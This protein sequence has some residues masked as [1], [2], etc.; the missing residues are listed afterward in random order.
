MKLSAQQISKIEE[1]LV[2]NGIQYDDIKLELTDHI[3]SE[4]EEEISIQGLSF[5]V[6]LHAV[7]ENWKEQLR[8]CTSLWIGKQNVLPKIIM[9]KW[10]KNTKNQ[11]KTI[12]S[13]SIIL[14]ILLTT[15]SR[16]INNEVVFEY[17]RMVFKTILILEFSLFM[18]GKYMIWKSNYKTTF[19]FF[20][21]AN[22]FPLI[23]FL[24]FIGI[25]LFPIKLVTPS[26]GLNVVFNFFLFIYVI[27]PIYYFQQAYQHF[28]FI[29][30]IKLS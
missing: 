15:I 21:K 22:S 29:K 17:F 27:F 2:L 28:R 19:S 1:T 16:T 11:Q 20:Y 8:P 4:I 18:V 25:G 5:E 12:L 7:F 3:A 26:L 10:T 30:K 23:L 13:A 9:D 14:A 6:A 24:F